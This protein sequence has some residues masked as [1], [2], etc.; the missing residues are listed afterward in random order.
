MILKFKEHYPQINPSAWIA[1][2]ADVIGQVTI[3]ENSSVWFQC[4]LRSD[5]NKIIIGKNT[6]IQ[7][8][9]MIHTDVDSQ[10]IIGDNVTIGHKVMLHGC[11]IED[12]CLIGMSATILDNAVIGQGS[13]VGANSLVTSGKVFPPNSLIMGSPA[14]VV[15]QLTH[16]DEQGLINHAAHYV[17]YKND[18]S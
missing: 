9:S 13:I 18:Y 1:P 8:L 12:N 17:D 2:S 15:K 11:K 7:D 4:V 16:E 3:G 10:T 5:V 14:K 6:N